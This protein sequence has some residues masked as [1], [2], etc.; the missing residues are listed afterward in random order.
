MERK[1]SS[2]FYSPS[3]LQAFLAVV[4]WL[5]AGFARH[6]VATAP[7][8]QGRRRDVQ[9]MRQCCSRCSGCCRGCSRRRRCGSG[10]AS[11]T[12]TAPCHRHP[13]GAR[14]DID[15]TSPWA[16]H[17][18]HATPPPA[19]TQVRP[20]RC[21][22]LPAGV[23]YTMAARRDALPFYG[24]RVSASTAANR[25]PGLYRLATAVEMATGIVTLSAVTPTVAVV[26]MATT[27]TTPLLA[28]PR[29]PLGTTVWFDIPSPKE[30][31]SPATMMAHMTSTMLETTSAVWIYISSSSEES[32]SLA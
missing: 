8:L 5:H 4:F 23:R 26:D 15:E 29:F 3:S 30:T 32:S 13:D 11:T 1:S 10:R 31:T 18:V 22:T 20:R 12:T 28:Q 17:R 21:A 16:M 25:R 19:P 6:F 2:S 9:W 14:I 7:T 27:A 24:R